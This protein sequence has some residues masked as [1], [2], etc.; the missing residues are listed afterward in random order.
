MG[1]EESPQSNTTPTVMIASNLDRSHAGPQP[2]AVYSPS[3]STI[4]LCGLDT[5]THLGNTDETGYTRIVPNKS[6]S[7]QAHNKGRLP[8]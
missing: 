5:Q 6:A 3:G 8:S 2:V 1:R 4:L 7:G